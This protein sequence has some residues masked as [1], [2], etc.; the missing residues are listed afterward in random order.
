MKN[1]R[2]LS[3]LLLFTFFN[4]GLNYSLYS[5]NAIKSNRLFQNNNK[6]LVAAHRG[7]WKE[8]PEN[9]IPAIQSCIGT[10]I[11]IVEIDVQRTKDGAYILMHDAKIDRT[12]NGKGKVS[13]YTLKELQRFK[14]RGKGDTLS[15]YRIPTLDTI[16]KITKDRIVVNIDKSSGRCKELTNLID[17]LNCNEHVLLKGI[18]SGEYFKNLNNQDT[19]SI[20]YMPILSTKSKID[21]FLFSYHPPL[22]EFLLSNDSSIYSSALFLN[23]LKKWNIRIWYNALFN[24]ISGGHTES[25]DA[26]NSWDW[27]INHDAYVIQTDYPFH[28]VNYLN[29]IGLHDSLNKEGIFDLSSLPLIDT[30]RTNEKQVIFDHTVKN[31]DTSNYHEVKSKETIYSISRKYHITTKEIYRL[32]PLLKKNSVI[33][34][35]QQLLIR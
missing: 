6:V 15:E 3:L 9:S 24:S 25:V 1:T 17:S 7:N 13:D 16:L 11:D 30:I 20:Y 21:T 5:Q 29:R 26:I 19:N 33:K 28:L 14:L 22:F 27:F 35:G 31:N 32:N 8:F 23:S 2:Y 12:T 34:T 4:V 18:G 10:G